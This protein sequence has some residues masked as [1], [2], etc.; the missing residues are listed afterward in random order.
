MKHRTFNTGFLRV[1]FLQDM[2]LMGGLWNKYT[3]FWLV[4]MLAD[5]IL[6][7]EIALK[8]SYLALKLHFSAK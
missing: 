1:R 6:D 3:P 5:N 7:W 2:K 4:G 8:I